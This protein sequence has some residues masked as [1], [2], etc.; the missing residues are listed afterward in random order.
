M[1]RAVAAIGG[2]LKVLTDIA[3]GEIFTTFQRKASS[4]Q[5]PGLLISIRR[6]CEVVIEPGDTGI[7]SGAGYLLGARWAM[8][9]VATLGTVCP[10]DDATSHISCVTAAGSAPDPRVFCATG[11]RPGEQPH[12][13]VAT[14]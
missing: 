1:A 10:V 8:S 6:R 3:G 11:H 12:A 14:G 9:G 2:L 13:P 5:E 7:H 4:C